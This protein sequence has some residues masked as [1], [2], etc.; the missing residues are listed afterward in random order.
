MTTKLDLSLAMLAALKRKRA[1][2]IVPKTQRALDALIRCQEGIIWARE[3]AD[4][5]ADKPT[6]SPP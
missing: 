1:Q 3:K 6:D 5:A 4:C 2:T